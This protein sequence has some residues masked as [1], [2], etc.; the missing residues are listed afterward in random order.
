MPG[1]T[2]QFIL[3]VNNTSSVADN[4]DLAASTDSSFAAL[5]LPSGWALKFID[6]SGKT[7][8]NTGSVAGK[9]AAQVYVSAPE[10]KLK[11][12]V[13]EL[14]AFAKTSKLDAGA[15][16]KLTFNIPAKILASFDQTNNQ[17]IVEPG[18]YKAYV[19][20]SSNVTDTTPVTFT[21][22]KEIVVSNTTA[23]ALALA[24]GVDAAS[25]TTISK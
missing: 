19:S 7:I 25:V 5:T 17:W 15:S 21:V 11:K 4:Y 13:I 20:P 23:G 3:Y 1:S 16:E 12:P 9:E 6:D 2:S 24:D 22:D 14:K 18:T 10:V 8:T